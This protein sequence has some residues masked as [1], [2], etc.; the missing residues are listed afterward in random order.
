[1][2]MAS[3]PQE[4]GARCWLDHY[5][6]GTPHTIDDRVNR[7][8]VD[9][10]EESQRKFAKCAALESFGKRL[11]YAEI[12][13][14]ANS[15][16]AYLQSCGVKKGDRVAIMLP[17]VAAYLP[18]IFGILK[19]GGV[20]VNTN[21]LYTPRELVHQITDAGARKIFYLSLFEETVAAAISAGVQLDLMVRVEVGDLIA[22]RA[23]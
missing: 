13:D 3:G 5:P 22:S 18:L 6:A 20:V 7:T 14:L 17:N 10:F 8:L 19:A 12:G 21:P 11:T 1:M 4:G 23:C 15:I 9:M 16:A 2:T